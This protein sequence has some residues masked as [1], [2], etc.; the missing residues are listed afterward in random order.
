[1][2]A[3]APVSGQGVFT[4]RVMAGVSYVASAI[5]CLVPVEMVELVLAA[6]RQRPIVTVVRIK[7]VVDVAVKTVW[8]VKPGASAKKHPAHKPVG[9]IVAVGGAVIGSVVEVP[10]WAHRRHA[11]A[12]GNLRRRDGQTAQQGNRENRENKN[13]TVGH[14]FSLI[15]LELQKGRG[16][17]SGVGSLWARQANG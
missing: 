5:P 3:A 9:P 15:R 14:N 1:M 10:V 7:A 17:V 8:A 4:A 13:L 16:V 11:N 12:D 2:A 6:T